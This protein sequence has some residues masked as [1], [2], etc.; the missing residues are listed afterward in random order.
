MEE[1]EYEK[2]MYLDMDDIVDDDHRTITFDLPYEKSFQS[3]LLRGM[4][5][6]LSLADTCDKEEARIQ[7][8]DIMVSLLLFTILFTSFGTYFVQGRVRFA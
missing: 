5:L 7:E 8:E 4:A 3:P 1:K 2:K 6:D